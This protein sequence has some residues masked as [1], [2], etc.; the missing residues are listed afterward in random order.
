[1]SD[2][3]RAAVFLDRDGVLNEAFIVDG[4]PNPPASLDRLHI[5]PGVKES[6]QRLSDLGF[7]LVVVTNQPDIARGSL[8]P[9][10]LESIHRELR[11]NLALDSIWVC[12]HDDSDR[13]L[14]RKPK[15]GLL[16]DAAEH[17]G[18]ALNESFMVG[19]RWRDIRAG[20][21]AGC[22]TALVVNPDYR[23]GSTEDP[24]I[25]VRNLSEAVDWIVNEMALSKEDTD[26]G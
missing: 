14:C 26:R 19:D 18:I 13:C 1:M 3:S 6:C 21:A 9:S 22:R 4:I 7:L 10:T 2:H 24:D 20:R 11:S 25:R 23:E 16:E 8:D 12:P 5:L 17:H 15:P